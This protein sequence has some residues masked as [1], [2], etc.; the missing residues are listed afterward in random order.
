MPELLHQSRR[1]LA[2]YALLAILD[3]RSA[4]RQLMMALAAVLMATVLGATAW[5]GCVVAAVAWAGGSTDWPPTLAAA[6]LLNLLAAAGLVWWLRTRLS[7]M[8]F[9]ATVRQ[10]RG[11]THGAQTEESAAH[12]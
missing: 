1:L 11:E 10:L 6:A 5:L 4:A 3:L 9:A 7:T 12:E 8:P 2:D